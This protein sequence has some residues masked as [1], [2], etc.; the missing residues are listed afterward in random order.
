MVVKVQQEWMRAPSK[1]RR[2]ALTLI[3]LRSQS[4]SIYKVTAAL[5]LSAA[6]VDFRPALGRETERERERETPAPMFSIQ[7]SVAAYFLYK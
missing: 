2:G 5:R 6:A 3:E 7:T 4:W 1:R